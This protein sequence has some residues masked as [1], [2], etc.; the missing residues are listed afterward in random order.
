MKDRKTWDEYFMDIVDT[1]SARSTCNRG[2]TGVVIV[3]DNQ[4]LSTG[5][6]GSIPGMDHCDDI[7][8]MMYKYIDENGNEAMH[9]VRTSHAELN[10]IAHAAKI[11]IN[12]NGATLYC[13][14][15]PCFTCLKVL[16]I[17]GIKRI[18]AKYRYH[19]DAL[20]IEV[21]NSEHY[22]NNIEWEILNNENIVYEKGEKNK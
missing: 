7:G 6:V 12:I 10:A 3:R 13:K 14:V 11:G 20:T 5:Y 1:V 15:M 9:C 18:V 2:R 19:A 4:I 8:H 21:F 22:K 16:L 17:A